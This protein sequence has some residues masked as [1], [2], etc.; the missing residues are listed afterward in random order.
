MNTNTDFKLLFK[1]LLA[2]SIVTI[3]LPAKIAFADN[4]ASVYHDMSKGE[5]CERGDKERH[6]MNEHDMP[7]YLHGCNSSA[8]KRI[9]YLLSLTRKFPLCATHINSTDS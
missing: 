5:H 3:S 7:P 4:G 1:Q 8:L 2:V 6:G 9:S